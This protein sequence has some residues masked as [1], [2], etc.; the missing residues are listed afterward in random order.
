LGVV[1]KVIKVIE[2][3]ETWI[4]VGYKIFALEGFKGIKIEKLA[5]KV[6][7]SKSSFYNYFLDLDTFIENLLQYHIQQ[8][9]ILADKERN[10]Q[11]IFPEL[12]DIL[13]EHKID[14]LFNRELRIHR[15]NKLFS[16]TLLKS[17]EIVGNSFVLVWVKDLNI[18]LSQMQLEA[19]F[20]LALENFFLQINSENLNHTWLSAY[21]LNLK[22]IAGSFR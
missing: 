19:I 6:G 4:Q 16:D 14:L 10:A 20:E 8:S 21:F 1:L 13:L 3:K 12:I 18:Q 9:Y 7:I 11:N 17:N 5:K 2:N 15:N 22:R